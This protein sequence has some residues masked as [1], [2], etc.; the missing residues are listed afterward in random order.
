MF[1]R[2]FMENI[3]RTFSTPTRPVLPGSLPYRKCLHSIVS[4]KKLVRNLVPTGTSTQY[5]TSTTAQ[6]STAVDGR[7]GA[8]IN[9]QPSLY[10]RRGWYRTDTGDRYSSTRRTGGQQKLSRLHTCCRTLF[11]SYAI[12]RTTAAVIK[13]ASFQLDFSIAMTSWG[14][15]S[16]LPVPPLGG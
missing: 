5:F 7:W 11:T 1:S 14:A 15:R 6:Q 16:T 2:F 10:S 3:P 4:D 8:N 12:I 13:H 9:A